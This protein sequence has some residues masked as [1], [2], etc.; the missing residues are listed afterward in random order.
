MSIACRVRAVT[1]ICSGG[2]GRAVSL[3]IGSLDRYTVVPP[4]LYAEPYR[5]P[6]RAHFRKPR[7]SK[8][9]YRKLINW[10][11]LVNYNS[12]R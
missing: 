9:V 4:N 8:V 7:G 5:G 10:T 1:T 12:G 2:M 11:G 3:A 6:F